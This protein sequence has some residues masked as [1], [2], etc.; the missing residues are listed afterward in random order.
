M[1]KKITPSDAAK[2]LSKL[3]ASKGGKARAAKLSPERRKEIARQAVN[4]RW[5]KPGP[6]FVVVPG[7]VISKSDGDRHFISARQL[8]DL[9][10]VNPAECIVLDRPHADAQRL[11]ESFIVLRPRYDGDYSQFWL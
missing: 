4:A 6:R 9:Y 3:G 2:A 5:V 8:I 11:M 7:E 1:P 10:R